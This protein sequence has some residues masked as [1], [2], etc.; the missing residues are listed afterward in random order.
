MLLFSHLRG[1]EFISPRPH[2]LNPDCAYFHFFDIRE[3]GE[4]REGH[5]GLLSMRKA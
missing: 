1:P 2:V 5:P 4:L 3:P